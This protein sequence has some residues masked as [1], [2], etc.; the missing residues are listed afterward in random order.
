MSLSPNISFHRWC[1]FFLKS[2]QGCQ[3][4]A[5][6]ERRFETKRYQCTFRLSNNYVLELPKILFV[7]AYSPYL[8][9]P[10]FDIDKLIQ[11]DFSLQMSAFLYRLGAFLICGDCLNNRLISEQGKTQKNP[12]L[13]KGHK[14]HDFEPN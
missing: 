4:I 3:I 14:F 5:I 9:P 1:H 8:H 10:F 6:V 13:H 7:M 11:F 2:F 12:D